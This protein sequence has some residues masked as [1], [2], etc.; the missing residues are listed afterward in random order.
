MPEKEVA[1]LRQRLAVA[2]RQAFTERGGHCAF[3]ASE[4]IATIQ[5]M[6]ARLDTGHWPGTSPARSPLTGV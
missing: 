2:L 1:M 3:T 5:A 4:L 6:R